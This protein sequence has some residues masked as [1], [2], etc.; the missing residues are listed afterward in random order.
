[1]VRKSLSLF[2]A[3]VF[4]AQSTGLSQG[5]ELALGAG[6]GTL[7]EPGV[8][9]NPSAAYKPPLLKGVR[10]DPDQ[11]FQFN[12]ILDK[13][14]SKAS[15]EDI[16]AESNHLIKYFLAALTVP[17]ND[18]WVNLSPYEKDRIITD[19]FGLTEMGRDLLAQDYILKQLT[20]SAIYP[21]SET[22]R[23]FWDEVYQ[24]A[25]ERFGTTDI[26]VDTFNKVWIVPE[27]AVVYENSGAAFVS[28]ARLK[29]M[30]E[31]DYIA[32]RGSDNA[33]A[34]NT[35][36]ND[37]TQEFGKKI[38]REVVIP[39]LEKEVNEGENFAKLRQVYYSLILAAWYKRKIKG[40][41][42]S[43]VYVDQKKVAGVN[44]D[45][46]KM[47]EKIWAQ[48][49]EAFKKGAYN[50]IREE[51]DTLS[52]ELIP[53][54]Y[55]SGGVDAINIDA[56]MDIQPM[57]K[58]MLVDLFS[59]VVDTFL[60]ITVACEVAGR[61][62]RTI[63][64]LQKVTPL[65][66]REIWN[67]E[68]AL[69][70]GWSSTGLVP[71]VNPQLIRELMVL[72]AVP[73]KPLRKSGRLSQALNAFFLAADSLRFGQ[74]R[75]NMFNAS[76]V[77][78]EKVVAE[79]KNDRYLSKNGRVLKERLGEEFKRKFSLYTNAQFEHIEAVLKYARHTA[80]LMEKAE[81]IKAEYAESGV[82]LVDQRAVVLAGNR[83]VRLLFDSIKASSVLLA[84]NGSNF[85]QVTGWVLE[86]MRLAGPNNEYLPEVFEGSKLFLA[87]DKKY[88][89]T[90][91]LTMAESLGT[92]GQDPENNV[93]DFIHLVDEAAPFLS[94]ERIREELGRQPVFAQLQARDQDRMVESEMNRR[95]ALFGKAAILTKGNAYLLP[96]I[97]RILD[98][99]TD[100]FETVVMASAEA[101][102]ALKRENGEGEDRSFAF[103]RIVLD[104]APLLKTFS[105]A[106]LQSSFEK[107][108]SAILQIENDPGPLA[109]AVLAGREL[110][111]PNGDYME[112]V[113][114]SM[115][116]A[117][118]KLSRNDVAKFNWVLS[119]RDPENQTG[120]YTYLQ[121]RTEDQTNKA[122]FALGDY[123][124]S[125]AQG[126]DEG[127]RFQIRS[128]LVDALGA[129]G[130]THVIKAL[131]NYDAA[132][133][134]ADMAMASALNALLDQSGMFEFPKGGTS[135]RWARLALR[136]VLFN[137]NDRLRAES[138]NASDV[139]ELVSRFAEARAGLR[140]EFD[141]EMVFRRV[142]NAAVS[143]LRAAR[144]NFSV[145]STVAKQATYYDR[146]PVMFARMIEEWGQDLG[147]LSADRMREQLLRLRPRDWGR[148]LSDTYFEKL[149][150]A[151]PESNAEML[152]SKL[153]KY[154]PAELAVELKSM[155]DQYAQKYM[156]H[157]RVVGAKYL[158]VL[159]NTQMSL[160]MAG[161]VLDKSDEISAR[162]GI[163]KD[164]L[165]ESFRVM[166]EMYGDEQG[167][168]SRVA[169]VLKDALFHIQFPDN[170]S[171]MSGQRREGSEQL[172][173][174]FNQALDQIL[175]LDP[176]T[177]RRRLRDAFK[178]KPR[179]FT[180]SVVPALTEAIGM[181]ET[182]AE[183]LRKALETAAEL[184]EPG[185]N[186]AILD[187]IVRESFTAKKNRGAAL[188][189][190]LKG[191]ATNLSEA[192]YKFFT[193]VFRRHD[194]AKILGS[195]KVGERTSKEEV[196]QITE[197]E[198]I[199]SA[200]RVTASQVL[201]DFPAGVEAETTTS[202]DNSQNGGI[203]L[204]AVDAGLRVNASGLELRFN[205]DSALFEQYRN[206]SGF[207]PVILNVQPFRDVPAFFGLSDADTASS[208]AA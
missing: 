166:N 171:I 185:K 115:G 7:P 140:Y 8:M 138:F 197:R 156:A 126:F 19:E 154:P 208:P 194:L 26:P 190:F 44:I 131:R 11:P 39:I 158:E 71:H 89:P 139:V 191:L 30:L 21:D 37:G 152:A 205:I 99:D 69:F 60:R 193:P 104:F 112:T 66:R 161:L 54:K 48:Y 165:L 108:Q 113:P 201:K 204:N 83:L 64:R 137:Q 91:V 159:R 122:I 63:N 72:E 206:A 163:N 70:E 86:A 155:S 107:L 124:S 189:A 80:V 157:L 111:G 47:S 160:V 61:V 53:H 151:L 31:S 198:F 94:A 120:V 79:L 144:D 16:K 92:W 207:V 18:L 77:V 27:K 38:I 146:D 183:L 62:D 55:F 32:A 67:V 167:K 24:K 59:H 169:T 57:G 100:Y 173:L 88:W 73:G 118:Q 33:I 3:L 106:K 1:M 150:E 162:Y 134:A 5:A 178:P 10:V 129:D 130:F 90:L 58:A 75:T 182:R 143:A 168:L 176:S 181:L 52:G 128:K 82:T 186:E 43:T 78:P 13:G 199:K 119:Y 180:L 42:L 29:V 87:Q 17:E 36:S 116:E 101:L 153:K 15:D 45:D 22:G 184:K 179:Q 172:Q 96:D 20:A 23:K 133:G 2:I 85:P 50:L 145:L 102:G 41:L 188:G 170:R 187:Q 164:I 200:V 125:L 6:A 121:G 9:I 196:E 14:D 109:N 97:V 177:M 202:T 49:V 174:T 103:K 74:V 192:E 110:M 132:Q 4:F 28:E 147:A 142:V 84:E 76:Y 136:D 12:F 35:A 65:T 149:G 51:R 93:E 56:A 117:I 95:L 98:P 148:W 127:S 46:P 195:R 81:S 123:L 135:P 34:V 105:K 68:G 25:R 40:S 141:D 175:H 203:D 114:L